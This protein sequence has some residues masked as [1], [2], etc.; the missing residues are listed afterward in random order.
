MKIF[1]KTRLKP[2]EQGMTLVEVMVAAVILAIALL[3]LLG[4]LLFASRLIRESEDIN[5][6]KNAARGIIE[7]MRMYDTDYIY[8]L[9]NSN[10]V[11]D[12]NGHGTAPGDN[13]FVEGLNVSPDDP[14]GF[15]GKIEFPEVSLGGIMVLSETATD[16]ELGMPRDL[17]GDGDAGD[18][19][20]SQDYR[21]L[22]VTVRIQWKSHGPPQ[23]MRMQSFIAERYVPS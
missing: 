10:P 18:A 3:A 20:V 14:D 9:Y 6:A 23:E 15:V 22:P 5:I 4:S 7:S 8:A 16:L 11:D 13:F 21:L 12:P 2:G 17:N 1:S 19:D